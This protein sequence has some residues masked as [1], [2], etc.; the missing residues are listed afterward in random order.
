MQ[1]LHPFAGSIQQ[2]K[3]QLAD[4]NRHRPCSCMLC[5]AKKPLR[6]HGF[7]SRTVRELAFDGAIQVR[8][9][10][11]RSCR[12]TISL[13]PEFVLPYLRCAIVVIGLFLKARLL[14]RKTLKQSAVA[15]GNHEMPYQRGQ[16]WIRRFRGQAASL[17]T[18][19]VALMRPPSAPDFI[20]RALTM[21][22][23]AG[24]VAAHRFLFDKL[25]M[26]LLGWPP[27]LAPD[28]RRCAL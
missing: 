27:S 4:P 10:L 26:H 2:Y 6:A 25:R 15:A 18:A 7:Y 24:W 17:A 19:L 16:Q 8:R 12:R 23:T 21:L 28:G 5:G 9:Y 1:I 22:E 3:E 14:E 20:T 13:L 11:C